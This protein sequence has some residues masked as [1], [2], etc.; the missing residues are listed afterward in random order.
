MY[1]LKKELLQPCPTNSKYRRSDN[2]LPPRDKYKLMAQYRSSHY[3]IL[4]FVLHRIQYS[5]VHDVTMDAGAF[6]LQAFIEIFG[7]THLA[8]QQ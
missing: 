3:S 4:N 8:L 2:I 5:T 6:P 7:I 1:I